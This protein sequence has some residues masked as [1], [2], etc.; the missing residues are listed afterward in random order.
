M[1]KTN[2][3][4]SN[5]SMYEIIKSLH[6]CISLNSQKNSFRLVYEKLKDDF[7]ANYRHKAILDRFSNSKSWPYGSG[8]YLI[9]EKSSDEDKL[10][11]IGKTGTY[12]IN[13]AGDAVIN[14]EE[15]NFSSR[16]NRW[17]PYCFFE[18]VFCYEPNPSCTE[19][20]KNRKP[21]NYIHHI[22]VSNLVVECFICG[23]NS[24]APAFLEALFLEAYFNESN[25]LP[26]ANRAF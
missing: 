18:D 1:N 12:K 9:W 23:S 16:P 17:T 15:K 4:S 3:D 14:T 10:I 6:T 24:V 2:S 19:L 8:V 26:P 7:K 13:N 22:L 11:Y 20:Q 5:I 21:E 25:T